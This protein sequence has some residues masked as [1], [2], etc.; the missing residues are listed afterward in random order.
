MKIELNILLI[1]LIGPLSIKEATKDAIQ[2]GHPNT[3][4]K[5]NDVVMILLTLFVL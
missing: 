3:D 5:Q 4:I 1:A 2:N